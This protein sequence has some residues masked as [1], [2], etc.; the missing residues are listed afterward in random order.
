MARSRSVRAHQQV[1][2]AAVALFSER[3]IE[4]TSM[5]A[6]AEASGVS[7]ATIYK[8]WADKEALCL[9][10]MAHIHGLDEEL[11]HSGSGTLRDDLVA[12]LARRPSEEQAALQAKI[13]PHFVAYG[14]RNLRF[15][16]AWRARVME[17]SRRRLRDLLQSGIAQGCL[18]ADLNLDVSETLLLG[19][20]LYSYIFRAL[21]LQAPEDLPDRVV[22]AFLR[23]HTV[24]R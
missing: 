24:G 1:L 5:D 20:M 19:P 16:Q 2:D 23:A 6:I 17:P 9:D 21:D 15:G 18:P 14:A 12:L 8:H 22:D 10:V 13:M 3:G 7:K 4:A 11:R